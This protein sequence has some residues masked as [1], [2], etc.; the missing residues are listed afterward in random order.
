MMIMGRVMRGRRVALSRH[1][2]QMIPAHSARIQTIG[3]SI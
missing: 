1:I 3:Y 2:G